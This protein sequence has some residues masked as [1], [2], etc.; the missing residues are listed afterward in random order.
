MAEPTAREIAEAALRVTSGSF[1]TDV[2]VL[3]GAIERACAKA[4]DLAAASTVLAELQRA[5]RDA[6]PD[7]CECGSGVWPC[8]VDGDK[9]CELVLSLLRT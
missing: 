4:S 7:P 2:M 5:A 3:A 6:C 8:H 9:A 1:E